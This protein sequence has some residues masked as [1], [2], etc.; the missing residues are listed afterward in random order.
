MEDF[1]GKTSFFGINYMSSRTTIKSNTSTK[2][3]IARN[4]LR[5]GK[6]KKKCFDQKFEGIN[7]NSFRT[8]ACL[9]LSTVRRNAKN[10]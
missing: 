7:A 1:R 10:N 3:G 6:K 4:S 8:S 5:I 2:I 9:A